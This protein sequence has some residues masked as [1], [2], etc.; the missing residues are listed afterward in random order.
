MQVR[1]DIRTVPTTLVLQVLLWL[2]SNTPLYF[3]ETY[4]GLTRNFVF[5]SLTQIAKKLVV[6]LMIPVLTKG[7]SEIIN[8]S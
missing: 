8:I 3:D 2:L 5:S 6:D 7:V 1:A 4:V